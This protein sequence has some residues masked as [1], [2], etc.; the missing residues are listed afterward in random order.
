MRVAARQTIVWVRLVAYK[1]NV[2][3]L[4]QQTIRSVARKISGVE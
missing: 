2:G 3:N 1:D 4:S